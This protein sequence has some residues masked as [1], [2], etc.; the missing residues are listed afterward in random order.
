MD[1]TFTYWIV[2]GILVLA[3]LVV[4]FGA[5]KFDRH[6][7]NRGKASK[8]LKKINTLEHDGQ[9]INYLRK[10]DPFV[11][12]ELL[13]DSFDAKGYKIKRNKR[14]TGDCGIDGIVFDGQGKK[15]LVQ[16]K[17]YSG[18]IDPGHVELFSE[19]IQR[20]GAFAG[21][22]IHTGKTSPRTRLKFRK[23]RV[24]IIGGGELIRLVTLQ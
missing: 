13:L 8:V 6:K 10:I 21:Y 14:Y 15:I 1:K 20:T 24:R 19:L 17:R 2:I 7:F 12:E 4:F 5:R 11:F 9:K 16:A 3:V 18:Y 23:G 22:F